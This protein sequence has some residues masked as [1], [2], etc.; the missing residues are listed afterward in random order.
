[1]DG[2]KDKKKK[3]KKNKKGLGD[4]MDDTKEFLN[5]KEKEDEEVIEKAE[6]PEPT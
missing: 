5:Y 4:F 2:K 1:M 3:K 6:E